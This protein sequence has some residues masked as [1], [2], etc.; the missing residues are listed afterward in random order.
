LQSK[1][2]FSFFNFVLRFCGT[3]FEFIYCTKMIKSMR[4]ILVLVFISLSITAISQPKEVQI[5]LSETFAHYEN[6]FNNATAA[7]ELLAK[8]YRKSS[9]MADARYYLGSAR[10]FVGNASKYCIN[11]SEGSENTL[12]LQ[13]VKDCEFSNERYSKMNKH[14]VNA[15][16]R[17]LASKEELDLAMAET[18]YDII[19]KFMA[20]SL[21]I[22][23]AGVQMLNMA[24]E[25]MN[26]GSSNM[27]NCK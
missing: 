16:E 21:A 12:A 19:G 18:E 6:A 7:Y 14:F 22:M 10:K 3:I 26:S 9:T 23:Q 13:V 15:S 2:N 20:S 1:S 17:F 25:E 5:Q 4:N 24:I 27:K 11:A 8:G